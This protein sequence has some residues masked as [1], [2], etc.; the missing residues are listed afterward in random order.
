MRTKS[1]T[2]LHL[3][4]LEKRTLLSAGGVPIAPTVAAA[5]PAAAAAEVN[6]IGE[7]EFTQA[8]AQVAHTEAQLTYEAAQITHGVAPLAV[9]DTAETPIVSPLFSADYVSLGLGNLSYEQSAAG[10]QSNIPLRLADFPRSDDL[11]NAALLSPDVLLGVSNQP[12]ASG[13]AAQLQPAT[14][15]QSSIPLRLADF[16]RSDDLANAALLSPDVLLGVSNQL[17]ASDSGTLLQPAAGGQSSVPMRLADFPRS[18][19]PASDTSLSTDVPFSVSNQLDNSDNGAPLQDQPVVSHGVMATNLAP[20]SVVV[21][22]YFA[23]RMAPQPRFASDLQFT[24]D[25]LAPAVDPTMGLSPMMDALSIGRGPAGFRAS[26]GQPVDVVIGNDVSPAMPSSAP[27]AKSHGSDVPSIN[28]ASRTGTQVFAAEVTSPPTS[29]GTTNL[30]AANILLVDA[31]AANSLGEFISFDDATVATPQLGILPATNA[32]FKGVDNA[33]LDQGN[34]LGDILP[35]P[36]GAAG[37]VSPAGD[38][39]RS[40]KNLAATD[41]F[42]AAPLIYQPIG[43]ADEGG[44]IELAI[45]APSPGA[46]GDVPPA[47]ESA[48]DSAA[49]QLSETRSESNV[50]LFCDVEV[51]VAPAL[52]TDDSPL[53]AV[54]GQSAGSGVAA[55]AIPSWK[56]NAATKP[57][58]PLHAWPQVTL[59]GLAENLPLLLG[60]TVLVSRG[61]LRLEEKLSERERRLRNMETLRRMPRE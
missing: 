30:L 43:D 42:E 33:E 22:E 61:G 7:H 50:W 44:S 38:S 26:P 45:A 47:G 53:A 49:R 2:R 37:V 56:A 16:P 27:S 57:L 18:D 12:G 21:T 54:P 51:A 13:S 60:V 58:S 32:G 6:Q 10:G 40:A 35:R 11:A 34:W 8:R 23:N 29:G 59:A 55:T 36:R 41:T 24:P 4:C 9:Q 28:D 17:G 19:D 20:Y 3:E 15:G 31:T 39:A 1:S 48:A 52:K 25:F 5:W 46:A 14:G